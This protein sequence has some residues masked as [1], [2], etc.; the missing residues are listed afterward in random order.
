MSYIEEVEW[1]ILFTDEFGDWWDTL[2]SDQQEAVADRVEL[3]QQSGPS[4]GRPT[5]DTLRGS[6]HENMKELRASKGGA[7]RVLVVFDPIRRAVLLLGGDKTGRL[8]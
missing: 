7:L 3:L 1:E 2:T 4:L 6:A 5:V 8:G